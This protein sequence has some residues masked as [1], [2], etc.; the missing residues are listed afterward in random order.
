M[1]T[2]LDVSFRWTLINKRKATVAIKDQIAPFDISFSVTR[3]GWIFPPN[4]TLS[5]RHGLADAPEIDGLV[6][7]SGASNCQPGDFVEVEITGSDSHDLQ[8]KVAS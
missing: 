4:Q 1:A 8:A 2:L 6:F 3:L 5:N 7:I